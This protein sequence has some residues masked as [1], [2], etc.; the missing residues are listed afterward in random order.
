MTICLQLRIFW[1]QFRCT[2]IS[3]LN[4]TPLATITIFLSRILKNE[5]IS[6]YIKSHFPVQE[7]HIIRSPLIYIA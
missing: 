7:A 6:D 1:K 3:T 5:H 4:Q 2:T